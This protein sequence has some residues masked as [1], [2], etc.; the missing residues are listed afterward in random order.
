MRAVNLDQH[1][2]RA[3]VVSAGT[4]S[5]TRIQRTRVATLATAWLLLA[6]VTLPATGQGAE[7]AASQQPAVAEARARFPAELVNFV[8]DAHN[9]VFSGEGPGHWD[10]KIRERGWILREADGYHLWYTGYDGTREGIKLLGYATSPDGVKW[11]RWPGNPLLRDQWIEDMMVVKDGDTYYLFA[12][13]RGDQPHLFTSKDKTHWTRQ[14]QLDIRYAN[15]QPI[16]KGVYGTPTAWRENGTWYLFYE[17][18]DLGVWLAA[19][20]DTKVWTHVQDE[21]VLVPGPADYDKSLIAMDQVIKRDGAYFAYYHGNNRARPRVWNTC[22]ARSEDLLHWTKYPQNPIVD[23][24]SSG[25]VVF[26]DQGRVRLY[27]MHEQI[28]LFEPADK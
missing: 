5:R 4:D 24:K 8:P 25:M 22:V 11:T 18:A 3:P 9:P 15:G 12:E 6:L 27:T 21:P 20:K 1:R 23:D 7:P 13:G 17:R 2:R 28:D 14:G 16:A 26:D 10:V 19:S